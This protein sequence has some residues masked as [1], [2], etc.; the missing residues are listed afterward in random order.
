MQ[1]II[2]IYLSNKKT[3][4]LL[5][6]LCLYCAFLLLCRAKL[7]QSIFYFF[8]VWNLFLA[9][10]PYLLLQFAKQR[11]QLFENRKTR[12]LL[13]LSWLLFLPNSFYILTDFVHLQKGN[14]DLFWFDLILLFSFASLGFLFGLLA[15]QEYKNCFS[16]FYSNKTIKTSIP[17]IC[18]LSG[19]GIYLGRFLRFNSWHILTN[20]FQLIIDAFL[21]LFSTEALLFSALYGSFIYI[22]C[23]IKNHFYGN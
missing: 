5:L 14:P 2:N 17:I 19:F 8:L 12:L 10:I 1:S 6:T 18:L 20:P 16:L 4:S 21:C 13:F 15:I 3:N 9:A 23:L 7:T 11:I 22:T